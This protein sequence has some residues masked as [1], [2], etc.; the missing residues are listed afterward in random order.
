RYDTPG[1]VASGQPGYPIPGTPA[2]EYNS[3]GLEASAGYGASAGHGTSE[4][5]AG[6]YAQ[7]PWTRAPAAVPLADP[8]SPSW[9]GANGWPGSPDQRPPSTVDG[10]GTVDGQTVAA[11][12]ETTVR[13]PNPAGPAGIPDPAN[14][15]P[16]NSTPAGGVPASPA[17]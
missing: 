10:P 2:P 13:Y 11:A 8:I 14:A 12:E 16:V 1:Y 6:G 5:G 15:A 9:P 7:P 3:A 17:P 4:Q